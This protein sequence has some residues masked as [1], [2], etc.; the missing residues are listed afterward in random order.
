MPP[1]LQEA[2]RQL[3]EYFAGKRK[4]FDLPLAPSG[5]PFQRSVWNA[6][7]NI[8]Y[9]Q[10]RSY[11]DLAQAVGRPN[12]CR[13][14]GSANAKNPLPILIPCHRVVRS[15]GST[16]GYAGGTKLKQILLELEKRYA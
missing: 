3:D 9:G 8:P 13:A 16:G 14:V 15:D 2:K 7:R 11:Q 10:T 1:L 12:A 5:T 4:T 6:L